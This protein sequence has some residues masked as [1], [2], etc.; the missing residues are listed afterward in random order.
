MTRNYITYCTVIILA[1]AI[2]LAGG[3]IWQ[4]Q[5]VSKAEQTQTGILSVHGEGIVYGK[6]TVARVNLGVETEKPNA[7]MAQ[8]ENAKKMSEVVLALMNMGFTEDDI[9]TANF[10]IYPVRSSFTSDGQYTIVGYRV[11][12]TLIVTVRDIDRVG[13]VLD[14]ATQ[15]GVNTVNGVTFD[16]ED[17]NELYHKAL[18]LAVSDALTKAEVIA[19]AMGENLGKPLKV[20]ESSSNRSAKSDV[21][22]V[23]F[24]RASAEYATPIIPS[25]V[26]VRASVSVE[27]VLK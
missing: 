10:S 24:M 2:V 8:Q 22:D 23:Q 19:N 5:G 25:D 11:S 6:P 14:I 27:Y 9:E 7:K 3:P 1:V 20:Y 4:T 26:A 17:S 13:D 18:Q 16:I 21:Y 15:A 12:N